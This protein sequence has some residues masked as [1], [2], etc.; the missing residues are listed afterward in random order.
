MKGKFRIGGAVLFGV[1]VILGAFMVQKNG[2]EAPSEGYIVAAAPERTAIPT[3]DLNGDGVPDWEESLRARIFE[4]IATPTSTVL[5]EE[6][7]GSYERPVTLTGRFSEAFLQD[8]LEG[9]MD[10]ADFSDPSVLVGNAV[11]AID[12]SV[13]SKRYSPLQAERTPTTPDSVRA[14]GNRIAEIVAMHSIQNENEAAI[15]QRALAAD[16]PRILQDLEPIQEVYEK[17]IRDALVMPVP[18]TLVDE[19]IDFLNAAEAV[20][21]DIVAMQVA[22]SDPLY[23]LARMRTYEADALALLNSLHGMA[24][25]FADVGISF[26]NDE[27][28]AVFSM[29]II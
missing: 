4:T 15:L 1:V 7:E 24:K 8:Y 17:I 13:R 6:G 14:Y 18:E 21:T 10:G 19:H 11:E 22:F 28:G 3:S 9:K 26:R 16:D 23:T 25:T 20:K 2:N 12:G 5:A 27:L 29:F